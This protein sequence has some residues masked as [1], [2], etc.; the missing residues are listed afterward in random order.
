MPLPPSGP[1]TLLAIQQEFARASLAAASTPAG[2]DPLPT[3]MR[4]FMGLTNYVFSVNV[5][6]I[7]LYNDFS[8]NGDNGFITQSFG[9][10]F[11]GD[12]G[13]L[14][15]VSGDNSV[16]YPPTSLTDSWIDSVPNGGNRASAAGLYDFE[17]EFVS[18]DTN[19][20]SYNVGLGDTVNLVHQISPAFG[21]RVNLAAAA[22]GL[23]RMV[24]LTS[25]SG[26]PIATVGTSIQVRSK[27]YSAGTN[28][29]VSN[30][31]HSIQCV[32]TYSPNQEQ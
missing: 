5:P 27:I 20:Y 12:N 21:T 2:L 3:S 4:D 14:T 30:V 6:P 1:I 11:F 22:P 18:G 15:Y 10:I 9:Q 31:L 13:V 16:Y 25:Y 8:N 28:N 7:S 26:N 32:A 24:E 17:W 29:L 19:N 23:V